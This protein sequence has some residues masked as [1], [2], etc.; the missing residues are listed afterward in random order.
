MKVDLNKP[1]FIEL[2]FVRANGDNCKN[3]IF[4][5]QDKICL[6]ANISCPGGHW[7]KVGVVP[8]SDDSLNSADSKMQQVKE[9][10]QEEPK[11]FY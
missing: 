7:E 5:T 2:K 8:Q 4:S 6:A 1:L 9:E 3:C 10:V 11:Y